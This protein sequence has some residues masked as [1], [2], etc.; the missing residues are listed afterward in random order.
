MP[1]PPLHRR[2]LLILHSQLPSVESNFPCILDP[3]FVTLLLSTLLDPPANFTRFSTD[4]KITPSFRALGFL[5]VPLSLS[6]F[7]G[8]LRERIHQ[9]RGRISERRDREVTGWCGN[10]Q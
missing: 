9:V 6:L 2:S 1:L 4:K 5:V 7:L 8:R 10:K 3:T